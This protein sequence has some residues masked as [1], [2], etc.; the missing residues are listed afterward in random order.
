MEKW[1]GWSFHSSGAAPNSLCG[2]LEW[3]DVDILQRHSDSG[4]EEGLEKQ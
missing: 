3:T 4:R 2:E 1:A